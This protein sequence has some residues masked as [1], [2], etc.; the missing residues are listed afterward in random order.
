MGSQP[1]L[2]SRS[3]VVSIYKSPRKKIWGSLPNLGRKKTSN[4]G[5][6]LFA[7]SALDTALSPVRNVALTNKSTSVNLTSKLF[8]LRDNIV[9]TRGN[10]YKIFLN[11]S[12]MNVRRH[13]LLN[14][15]PVCGT[16]CHPR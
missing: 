13:F 7:T 2:A 5:P 4:Y 6:L 12:R 9:P 1:N 16:V 10:P 8:K 3:E 14:V 15:L 11:T